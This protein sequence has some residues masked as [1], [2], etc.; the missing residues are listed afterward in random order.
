MRLN[1]TS[2]RDTRKTKVMR[3][4]S[5]HT[6]NVHHANMS[7]NVDPRTPDFYIVRL[8]FTGV[9]IIFLFLRHTIDCGYSS[10]SRF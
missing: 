2:Y 8:G 7:G 4:D 6:L 3:N 9:H 5:V 1:I 10:L